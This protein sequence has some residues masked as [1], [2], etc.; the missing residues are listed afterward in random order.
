MIL[1]IHEISLIKK[2]GGQLDTLCVGDQVACTF[3]TETSAEPGFS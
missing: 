1:E 2:K 3:A